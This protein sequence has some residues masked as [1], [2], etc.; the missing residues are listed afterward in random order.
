MSLWAM[1]AAA[2]AEIAAHAVACC[3]ELEEA[4][5]GELTARELWANLMAY[6]VVCKQ[7]CA[8]AA[9]RRGEAAAAAREIEAA[10]AKLHDELDAVVETAARAAEAEPAMVAAQE[11]AMAELHRTTRDRKEADRRLQYQRSR[12]PYQRGA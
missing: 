8:K 10:D 4:K 11:A 12:P 6:H 9:H 3:K 2:A 7:G 5:R 1:K